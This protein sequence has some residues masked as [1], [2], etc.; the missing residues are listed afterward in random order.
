M[1]LHCGPQPFKLCCHA[2]QG[3][4][5]RSLTAAYRWVLRALPEWTCHAGRC[6]FCPVG[7]MVAKQEN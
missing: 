7:G 6:Q 4:A 2:L 1:R 3:K 5:S